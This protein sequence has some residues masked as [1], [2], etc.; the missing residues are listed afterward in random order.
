MTCLRIRV[1]RGET[2]T[3]ERGDDFCAPL[4]RHVFD[5]YPTPFSI[6]C[7]YMRKTFS[8]RGLRSGLTFLREPRRRRDWR[9]D[10]DPMDNG[11]FFFFC[12]KSNF[13]RFLQ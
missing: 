3:F 8:V 4:R 2:R 11:N 9:T 1:V 10:V 7:K 13:N 5:I 12:Q 6:R